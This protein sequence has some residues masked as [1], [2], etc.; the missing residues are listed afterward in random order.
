MGKV[1]TPAGPPT[2]S[3]FCNCLAQERGLD[4]AGHAGAFQDAIILEVP[5]PWR[6][7]MYARAGALPQEVI[8]LLDLWLKRYQAGE[9]YPHR[10]LMV[11]PDAEYSRAGYRRVM[12]YTRQA[13]RVAAFEK[14]E[15]QV[16]E[17][18]VGALAWALF[19]ARERLGRF[20]RYRL[21][22]ASSV[23]DLL[24]CTHG[25]IDAACAKFGFPLYR[26][27]RREHA[28][29]GLRVWRVS[30][31]G[32]HVFAPTMMDMPTGHYWAYV[33][34]AQ[35]EAIVR[36][37]G[38]V[39]ALRGHYRGWAGLE[40]G[41]AQAAER[42]AWQQVGWTWVDYHRAGKL[43]ALDTASESPR[44]AEVQLEY[45]TPDG[46]ERGIWQAHVEVIRHVETPHTTSNPALHAY[47]QYEVTRLERS[48]A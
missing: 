21:L 22:E 29:E 45:T 8:D 35:A 1:T 27:L 28:H 10:P 30:H 39:A 47:P 31:F 18:E 42:D 9:G 38:D 7:D 12:V 33:N 15:Y 46:R 11:A 2:S 48:Q 4:P 5:L 25:S 36:R 40:P 23:R 26:S 16:P 6:P 19:E 24:V 41:F 34:E 44:W 20:E 14:L 13:G 43:V 3:A 32:G 17:S 37:S